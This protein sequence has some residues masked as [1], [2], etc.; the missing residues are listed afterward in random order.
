MEEK[1]RDGMMD[2]KSFAEMLDENPSDSGWLKPGDRITAVIVKITDEWVFL[3]LG[4]KSE[5]CLDRRELLDEGNITVKE[6]DTLGAYFLSSRHNEKFFTTRVGVG[7]SGRTYLED[8][9]RSGV[10]VEGKVEK[11]VKG[12]FEVKV[13]GGVRGFCP[14]SQTGFARNEGTVDVIGSSFSFRVMEYGEKGRNIVLSRRTLMEEQ[15]RLQKESRKA[16]LKEGMTVSGKVVSL[17]DFGAFVDIGGIQGLL[18]VSE[19]AWDRVEDIREVLNA[20][21]EIDAAII[22][23]D[24]A[25][26]RITLSMKRIM[27]DPWA[28]VGGRFPEG[29]IHRGRIVRLTKFGAFVNLGPGV[30][31]LVHI[32][33]LGK[34]KRINHPRDAV[35][36]GEILEV[37]VEKV[38]VEKKRLSLVPAGGETETQAGE[39]EDI[40]RF[41][42][43][44]SPAM[45]T[46]GDI[47]KSALAGKRKR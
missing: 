45:G 2:G 42:G 15:E 31:G 34:G 1:D 22:R 32:S 47:L 46:L 25:K 40:R 35:Q 41:I 21:Q 27:P 19:V 5:G 39:A 29:T 20:G 28:D 36:E 7:D 12:G 30:D 26:D 23:L 6:G 4:G 13:A 43:K 17:H 37:K 10:P 18:P 11:E 3:D 44:E 14:Y 16:E 24:A 9:W 8:A 33:K 38:D